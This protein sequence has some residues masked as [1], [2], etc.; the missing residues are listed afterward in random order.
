MD[1]PEQYLDELL[2]EALDNLDDLDTNL[3]SVTMAV[4]LVKEALSMC[5]VLEGGMQADR[6]VIWEALR[7]VGFKLSPFQRKLTLGY[8]GTPESE[9]W[10]EHDG[11]RADVAKL[12]T[13][14][15]VEGG[16]YV[17]REDA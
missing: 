17:R 14:A 4:T 16:Y 5:I 3:I 13:K 10:E 8:E 12:A 11:L 15:L 6:D 9:S 7:R 2:K 1:K